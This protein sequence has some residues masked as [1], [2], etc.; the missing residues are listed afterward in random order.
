MHAQVCVIG[1]GVSGLVAAAR[2]GLA[3]PDGDPFGVLVLEAGERP[4]GVAWSE[5]IEGRVIDLGP[6]SWLSG[7]P[8]LDRAIAQAGLEGQVLDAHP[9]AKSRFIWARGALHAV[10]MSPPALLRTRLLSWPAR[11]RMLLE[12]FI[13]RAPDDRDETVADFAARR[14]G[15]GVVERLL[16]PMVAG[17][18]GADPRQLSLKAA[19]PTLARMEREHGSLLLGA[20]RARGEGPRPRLQALRGGAGSLSRGLAQALGERLRLGVLVRGIE[21]RAEHFVVHTEQERITADAV[22]LATPAAA[23]ASL[24]RGLDPEAAR[25]LDEIPYAPMAIATAAW[26]AE[27]FPRP[28][29]GF[30]ALVAGDARDEVPVLGTLFVSSTFPSH[31]RPGE[32]L[33][34]T[35]VGGQPDPGAVALPDQQLLARCHAAHARMFGTPTGA[36]LA[37]HLHRIPRAIPQYTP[38]HLR[39]VALARKAQARHPGLFLVGSHLDGPGVRD[40]AKTA[41]E[42]AAQV[43]RWL[44]TGETDPGV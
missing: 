14:L 18:Y 9:G 33:L 35:M 11:L 1:G 36:P 32:V 37:V 2:L 31:A 10:P 39:R 29:E 42:A 21:A 27:A 4:G 41:A 23:Q 12:P 6:S 19:F 16:A 3:G 43:R 17:V 20:L 26:S 44:E 13:G 25:A 40:C 7:E 22:V 34:R 28:I 8:A 15:P 5:E 30:G 24:L 38:G